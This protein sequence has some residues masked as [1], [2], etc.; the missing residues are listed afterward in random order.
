MHADL[1][2]NA[3]A[4]G[5]IKSLTSLRRQARVLRGALKG[6]RILSRKLSEALGRENGVGLHEISEGLA[7][8]RKEST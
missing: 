3:R 8:T 4:K 1:T 6:D 7:R 2:S 5:R